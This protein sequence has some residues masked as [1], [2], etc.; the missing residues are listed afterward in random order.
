MGESERSTSNHHEP[1]RCSIAAARSA[2]W[3]GEDGFERR[4]AAGA[5]FLWCGETSE[6]LS[7]R[8]WHAGVVPGRRIHHTDLQPPDE[9]TALDQRLDQYRATVADALDGLDHGAANRRVLAATDLTVSGIVKHLAWVEDHW[10]QARLA[11]VGLPEP[12]ASAPLDEDYD[13]PFHSAAGDSVAS[14]LDLYRAACARSRATAAGAALD[15]V[16][17]VVSFGREPVNLRWILVH[18][19][20][21]T[22]RHAGH[23]DLLRDAIEAG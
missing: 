6:T 14:V 18:M 19:I 3:T 8:F 21:E 13:W 5:I 22:A 12:W 17:A 9:R 10:F 16:A 7:G 4:P 23:L 1:I 11:G 2:I 15:D 20:D